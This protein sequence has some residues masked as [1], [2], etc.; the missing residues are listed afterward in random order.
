MSPL[1][2][3]I[4]ARAGELAPALAAFALLLCLFCGYFMLRSVRETMGI[5]GGVENLQWLFS[6]TFIAMLLAVPAYGWLSARV[7]RRIFVDCVYLFFASNLLG[8]AWLLWRT[9]DP[10]WAARAFYVWLS[11]YNLFVVSLAWSLLADVFDRRQSKRL[12]PSIAAGASLGGLIGP[13]LG[14]LLVS[15]A[16]TAGLLVLAAIFLLP[17]LALRRYLMT[18]RASG[19]AGRPGAES[20]PP[21]RPVPG[22]P[23]AG[24]SL[25]LGSPYLLGICAFV[26]LLSCTSTFLYFEQARLVA[27][28]FPD[29][30]Q[31]VRVF[32]LI[33]FTV[34]A[35][36][37]ACQ[38]F[39]AGRV[40]QRFGV[41]ALLAVVPLLVALGFLALALLPQFAVLA[42]VMVLRRVGEYAFVRPGR[43]MLFVPLG[44]QQKYRAKNFIDTVVYRG[45]DAL[46]AWL[47][48]LLN[49]IGLT[50]AMVALVGAGVA[51]AWAALGWRLGLR[52][53]HTESPAT[54]QEAKP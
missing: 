33:D 44:A 8:F 31:Q 40:A 24:I 17:T 39:I 7:P 25:V 6:A 37:L 20:E 42:A 2:R 29:S 36:S 23:F 1:H 3:A 49:G 12:F 45:G 30:Q 38:L 28:L 48:T 21:E 10:L 14:G 15:D 50:A 4:H 41:G 13:L 9:P 5:A 43:E 32:A 11:V 18:W 54:S 35:L 52:H 22:N 47:A 34:Q 46:S 16:G 51:L 53:E 26:L 19:G 27:A